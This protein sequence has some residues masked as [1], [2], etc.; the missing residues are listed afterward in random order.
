[1]KNLLI[2]HIKGRLCQQFGH[3]PKKV[4]FGWDPIKYVVICR[5]CGVTIEEGVEKTAI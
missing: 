4:Y 5:R 3:K 1:M 2:K